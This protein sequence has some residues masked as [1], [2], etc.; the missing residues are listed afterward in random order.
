MIISK[1]NLYKFIYILIFLP[2]L[3]R[4][5]TDNYGVSYVFMPIFDLLAIVLLILSYYL[6]RHRNN[7]IHM[8]EF[9]FIAFI[10]VGISSILVNGNGS[11][12]GIFYNGRPY[13]RMILSM[14]ISAIV[15]DFKDLKKIFNY[16]E[17]LLY[18]NVFVMTYQ[19]IV[20]GLRQDIIGGTFGNSQ[21]S[22]TIQN[23][24]CVFVFSATLIMFL[25]KIYPTKKLVLNTLVVLYIASLAEINL[26][27]LEVLLVTI[28]A[29]LFNKDFLLKISLNKILLVT[30]GLFI[31]LVA[32]ILF[33]K[34]NPDR[35]FLLSIQNILEYLG[36]N[37]GSTGVYR[38]SR[39]KVFTQLGDSFFGTSKIHWLFGFGL[40]N[41]STHSEFYRMFSNLQYTFFSSS[42][43][44]LETGFC[45][46]F[47][48][49][50]AILTAFLFGLRVRN[51]INDV[52]QKAL[53]EVSI[54]MSVISIMM[55]FYNSTLRDVYTAFLSGTIMIAPYLIKKS[56]WEG[57]LE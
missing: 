17:L 2:F 9:W 36:F 45:G 5:L 29:L 53:I 25:K 3:A 4:F 11:L 30:S 37:E 56:K 54:I 8:L 7:K 15:L 47:V 19:Y 46:V 39:L 22:N 27:Y 16:L 21:G 28:I 51:K 23:I 13:L 10:V 50:G 6:I 41:C 48:N 43:T 35:V 12:E 18:V 44:F 32:V 26:V 31:A 52:E 40:G 42:M 38:I 34:F 14:L 57:K 33:M 24:T 20:L 49:I 1:K 55:F